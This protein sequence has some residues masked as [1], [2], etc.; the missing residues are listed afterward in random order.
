MTSVDCSTTG[1]QQTL[2]RADV[3]PRLFAHLDAADIPYCVL[4]D[5]RDLCRQS[6]VDGDIDIA[7]DPAALDT[8]PQILAGFCEQEGLRLVQCW[9]HEVTAF[10]YVLA[11]RETDGTLGLLSLDICSDF[12]R[13]GRPF[14]TAAHLVDGRQRALDAEAADRGFYVP[15]PARAFIYYLLKRVD[16]E[17]LEAAHGEYLSAVAGEDPEGAARE[18][19]RFWSGDQAGALLRAVPSGRWNEVRAR[20]PELRAAMHR[21][22]P[23]KRVLL[24]AELARGLRRLRRPTGLFVVFL[25]PDGSGKSSVIDTLI[26]RGVPAFRR[27]HYTHFRPRLGLPKGDGAPTTR[28]HGKRARRRLASVIK[29]GYY[30]ADYLAGY[31]AQIR[32]RLSFSTLVIFDRYYHDILV[33]PQRYRYGGPVTLAQTLR[34]LVPSPDL[35]ILLDAPAEVVHARKQEVPLAETVRARQEY[36]S[37]INSLPQGRVVDASRPLEQVVAAVED[38]ILQRAAEMTRRRV[39][40]GSMFPTATRLQEVERA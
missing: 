35:V 19:E 24:G 11:R 31:V 23:S 1:E 28:P 39:K 40:V 3:L 34:H 17:V 37:L 27:I 36:L 5:T 7:V 14:L 29:L 32:P 12:V 2:S 13:N 15:A 30:V 33:D 26:R 38:A 21:A 16:K 20:L 18:I 10:H 4:G 6:T 9:Q 22:L 25:G 8:L